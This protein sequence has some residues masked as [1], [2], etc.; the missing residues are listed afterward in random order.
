MNWR[1]TWATIMILSLKK[2]KGQKTVKDNL[3][4]YNTDHEGHP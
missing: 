3:I 1:P 2:K 4:S